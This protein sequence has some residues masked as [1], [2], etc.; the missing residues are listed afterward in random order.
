VNARSSS[1]GGSFNA[2]LK[3]TAIRVSQPG[4]YR[5]TYW[6]QMF[7]DS[8]FFCIDPPDYIK[9]EA[10]TD[11]ESRVITYTFKN[12]ERDSRWLKK[13]TEV[14]TQDMK[15]DVSVYSNHKLNIYYI[16][17]ALDFIL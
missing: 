11:L 17:A 7:C 13:N 1:N 4:K 12:I 3:W 8:L 14:Q 5:I 9:F 10:R 2:E 16:Q 6:I 15:I